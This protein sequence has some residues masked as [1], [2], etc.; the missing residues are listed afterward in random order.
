MQSSPISEYIDD[1]DRDELILNQKSEPFTSFENPTVHYTPQQSKLEVTKLKRLLSIP[2]IFAILSIILFALSFAYLLYTGIAKKNWYNIFAFT[3]MPL[4]LPLLIAAIILA[5]YLIKRI[6]QSKEDN[7]SQ[8]MQKF[9]R[10]TEDIM[11]TDVNGR[12]VD[13]HAEIERTETCL[14]GVDSYPIEV[15]QMHDL[16][17]HILHLQLWSRLAVLYDRIDDYANAKKYTDLCE[18]VE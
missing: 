14:N 17:L 8:V 6:R 1:D 2:I 12:D 5:F 9:L 13:F 18:S 4:S 7:Q 16:D 10:M 3:G 11:A 15:L